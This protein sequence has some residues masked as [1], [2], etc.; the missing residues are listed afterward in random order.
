MSINRVSLL[1]CFVSLV[2]LLCSS[3]PALAATLEPNSVSTTEVTSNSA[4]LHASINPE[5]AKTSYVLEYGPGKYESPV[6]PAGSKQVGAGET[7]AGAAVVPVEVHLQG[8]SANTKYFYR[9]VVEGVPST[10]EVSFT[11]QPVGSEFVLPDARQWELV[12][13]PDKYGG[14]IQSITEEGGVIQASENG[15]AVTYV[16]VNPPVADPLGNR[17]LQEAQVL[18]TRGPEGWSSEDI[19]T[20]HNT[21]G[22]VTLSK[23]TEYTF[24]SPDLSLGLVEPNGETPLAPPVAPG[25]AQERT[26]WLRNDDRCAPTPSEAIPATCY[27]ALVSAANTPRGT[28]ISER[29]SELGGPGN[30][31]EKEVKHPIFEGASP[32]LSHVVFTDSEPLVEGA[33]D[34]ELY[35]WSAGKPAG[36]QLQL[37]SVLPGSG[38]PTGGTL[39]G[40]LLHEVVRHAVSNDGSRVIWNLG[41]SLYL[42]DMG[43]KE[44]VVVSAPEP[45]GE[46][47]GEA[48]FQ[49]ASSDGS[50]V[51]FTDD[52]R[53]TAN[54]TA[55]EEEGEADLYVYEV[56]SGAGE[57]LAGRLTDLTVDA[58]AGEHAA[59]QHE[60]IGASEDGSYV[61]FVANGALGDASEHGVS[62]GNCVR[63]EARPTE[64]G[65]ACSLYVERF[66]GGGWEAPVFIATLSGNDRPDWDGE[67]RFLSGLTARV[68]PDGRWVAFMSDQ[69]LTGYDNVDVSGREGVSGEGGVHADE[70]VFLFDVARPVSEGVP[71]VVDNPLCASCDPSGARPVGV[72][73]PEHEVGV[74]EP[75]LLVDERGVWKGRWLA[76]SVPGWT[77]DDQESALYQSR[78]LSNSGRLFFDGADSLVA[79]DVNGREDVYE[80]EP[81]GVGGCGPGAVDASW[82]F[83]AGDGGC[84]GLISSGASGEESA[85][86][87]ASAVGG[88]DGEGGEGGGDVFFLSAS[89]LAPKDEDQAFDV[90]DA[91]EC[92]AGSPCPPPQGAVQPACNNAESCRA[93]GGGGASNQSPEIFGAPPS[94]TFNGQGNVTSEAVTPPPAVVKPKTKTIT[95]KKPKKLTHG[96]CVR[97]K[98]KKKGKKANRR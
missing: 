45:G 61:Y 86:L 49:S 98:A 58:N 38:G 85:F 56:T 74:L 8:L 29:E 52:A 53:L 17:A 93:A 75:T 7:G 3:A 71:G 68:S 82:V 54:S 14:S 64:A 94:A 70:E 12:S 16:S 50:K 79:A 24:F 10:E 39:G 26:I 44:T 47:G 84:V 83:V 36:E 2:A 34:E 31:L 37:V 1:A 32:D 15:G 55:D 92:S 25:E 33:G 28:K 40:G 22:I 46:A 65:R 4:T 66:D 96:K 48:K 35:E 9:V 62:K 5:S 30:P 23:L 88:S 81:A 19:A 80:F 63:N 73:D 69:R 42:R 97:A 72:F 13:P 60:I 89:Q 87:D 91:H 77:S 11:T 95:C 41:G 20:P 90:Y 57:P 59:V 78:Y 21:V 18:S 76:G 27:V 67:G 6:P 43:R 51:F